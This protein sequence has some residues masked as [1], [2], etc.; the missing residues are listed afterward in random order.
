MKVVRNIIIILLL[1]GLVLA[2]IYFI[3]PN[4]KKD[5]NVGKTNLVINYTNVTSSM[6]GKVIIDNSDIYISMDDV[7]NYYD[8]YIYYDEQYNYIIITRDNKTVC[9]DIDAKTLDINGNKISAKVI[10]DSGMYYVP[11]TKLEDIYNIKVHQKT[12]S[13]GVIIESLDRKLETATITKNTKLRYKRTFL[14]R[15]IEKLNVGDKVSIVPYR[16]DSDYIFVR[17]ENGNLGYVKKNC[18]SEIIVEREEIVEEQ[19]ENKKISMAWEYFE[20][21]APTMRNNQI[22]GVNVV[23]P[24][25]FYMDSYTVK[26]RIDENGL[27]YIRWAKSNDYEVWPMISNNNYTTENMEE[28]SNWINDYQKRKEVISQIVKYVDTYEFD[29]INI[30]FEN[31]YLKDK[32]GLSRF[33][34]ELK[35]ALENV[36]ATLS[37]DV[38]EPDGSDNWSL[39]FNRHVIGDVADYIVFMAYDQFGRE[40]KVAR[41]NSCLLL[42][43]KKYKQI[44][45]ARRSKS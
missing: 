26:D 24:S 41:S 20:T 21:T 42:G 25:F 35:P 10:E 34:I 33:I 37:V 28:F 22:H 11:I 32:D 38:T 2:G 9:F 6:K 3:A 13:S 1:I 36:G 17:S 29:G 15:A 39:C 45:G 18:L 14:S 4:Y 27:A 23:S 5:E 31:I 44:F 12:S 7:E 19:K 40:S 16:N 8:R 30:D 43:R